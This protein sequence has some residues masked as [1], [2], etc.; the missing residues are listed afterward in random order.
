M[1][2]DILVPVCTSAV[3]GAMIAAGAPSCSSDSGGGAPVVDAGFFER[4]AFCA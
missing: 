1:K 2:R 3:F 4:R